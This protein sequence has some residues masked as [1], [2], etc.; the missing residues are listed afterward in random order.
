VAV[1]AYDIAHREVRRADRQ[2]SLHLVDDRPEEL[3]PMLRVRHRRDREVHAAEAR[4][5]HS[6]AQERHRNSGHEHGLAGRLADP[7]R[8]RGVGDHRDAQQQEEREESQPDHR[9]LHDLPGGQHQEQVAHLPAAERHR[10]QLAV[11]AGQL[12]HRHVVQRSAVARAGQPGWAQ[13][14]LDPPDLVAQPA[15]RGEHG[16]RHEQREHQAEAP[17]RQAVHRLPQLAG[18]EEEQRHEQQQR[19]R[20]ALQ[21]HAVAHVPQRLAERPSGQRHEPVRR[22]QPGAGGQQPVRGEQAEHRAGV[23]GT[24]CRPGLHAEDVVGGVAA[25]QPEHRQGYEQRQHRV[26]DQHGH[27]GPAGEVG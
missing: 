9:R 21:A 3:P 6:V 5:Q 18:E 25:V 24:G 7:L 19:Q 27:R 23:E 26:R 15:G 1:A 14:L 10:L 22:D 17:P 20:P 12:G 16:D 2:R 8:R 4:E 13:V 11:A